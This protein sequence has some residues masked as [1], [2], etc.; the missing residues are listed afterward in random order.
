MEI[1][2]F[3]ERDGTSGRMNSKARKLLMKE[4]MV[5][6]QQQNGRNCIFKALS[7]A[8]GM[9][10]GRKKDLQR[11]VVKR[12]RVE[13][14]HDM[15]E[16]WNTSKVLVVAAGEMQM[17]IRVIKMDGEDGEEVETQIVGAHGPMISVALYTKTQHVKAL[18][19]TCENNTAKGESKINTKI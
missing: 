9:R 4:G 19:D 15:F 11:R 13:H 6:K 1:P 16:Q 14:C 17:R 3:M 10:P 12:V 8:A 5:E 18:I 2:G 7:D